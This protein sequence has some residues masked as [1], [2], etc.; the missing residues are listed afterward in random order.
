MPDFEGLVETWIALFG[1]NEETPHC[2]GLCRQYWDVDWRISKDRRALLDV[3]RSRF[4]VQF[5]PLVRILRSLTGSMRLENSDPDIGDLSNYGSSAQD[6][7]ESSKYVHFYFAKLPT[8]T[9]I[10]P[11]AMR[12][13]ANVLYDRVVDRTGYSRASGG[14]AYTNLRQ[15]NLPGGTTIPA[16]CVGRLLSSDSSHDNVVVAWQHEHSGWKLVV[17]VL[18]D[19]VYRRQGISRGIRHTDAAYGRRG[20]APVTLSV[21][22]IGIEDNENEALV[23]DGLELILSIVQSNAP[24]TVLLM[25]SLEE[26]GPLVSHSARDVAPPDLVQLIFMILEDVLG[27][28]HNNRAPVPSALIAPC[29]GILT[30]L[31]SLPNYSNRVWLFLRSSPILFGSDRDATYNSPI[32][33]SERNSG[34]YVM[35]LSLLRLVRTLLEESTSRLVPTHAE[36]P[37]LQMIKEEV[38][39]RAV[40]FIQTHIWVEHAG[41]RY[42]HLPDRFEISRSVVELYARILDLRA[43]LEVNGDHT[44]RSV[45]VGFVSG[46]FITH[47]AN[48]TIT[49]LVHAIASART[50]ISALNQARRIP[51]LHAYRELLEKALRLTRL[52]LQLKNTSQDAFKGQA[53]LEQALCADHAAANML[54]RASRSFAPD[55]SSRANPVDVLMH[56]I[57]Q[58]ELGTTIPIESTKV[59]TALCMAFADNTSPDARP[60]LLSYLSDAHATMAGLVRI[61]KHPYDDLDLRNALW[62]FVTT[63]VQIQAPL[64]VL[65]VAGQFR[66]QATNAKG[67]A[68]EGAAREDDLSAIGTSSSTKSASA[69]DAACTTLSGWKDLWESNPQLL[70][71]VLGFLEVVWS[72][73]LENLLSL[74]PSKGDDQFWKNIAAIVREELG[75]APDYISSK[76]QEE[77]GEMHSDLHSAVQYH[78]YKT[79]VKAHALSILGADIA[80]HLQSAKGDDAKTLPASYKEIASLFENEELFRDSISET[81][82]SSYDS[83]LFD[84]LTIGLSSMAPISLPSLMFREPLGHQQFGDGFMLSIPL[85]LA[86]LRSSL[87]GNTHM[88]ASAENIKLLVFSANQNMSLAHS[89]LSMMR[90]WGL[91]LG[92]V[93]GH[94][95]NSAKARSIL[96]SAAAL[97]SQD[98]A[99]ESRSGDF[100]A[101]IH[102]ARLQLLLALLEA[103]WYTNS[104]SP[105]QV[106][107]FM[108][109]LN[110]V[111][112]IIS[113]ETFPPGR[114]FLGL[115][116]DAFHRSL[117][118]IIYF[119]AKKCQYLDMGSQIIRA[120]YRLLMGKVFTSSLTLVIDALRLAFDTAR[121]RQ[122]VD[123]DKDLDLLVA[124]FQQCTRKGLHSSSTTWLTR[125]QEADVFSASLMLLCQT[126]MSGLSDLELLRSRGRPLYTPQVLAFHMALASIPFTAERL[127]SEGA[128]AAYSNN[129]ISV[130]LSEGIVAPTL[131]ELPSERSPAHKAY[132]AML[133]NVTGMIS[134]LASPQQFIESQV[135]GFVQ[136]YGLQI[137]KALSWTNDDPLTLPFLEE[138]ELSVKLFYLMAPGN[139]SG[140]S[141]NDTALAPVLRAFTEVALLLVQQLNYALTHPKHLTGILE[142][143]TVEERIRMEHESSENVS[144]A[145]L[146]D[147]LD[148][149]KRPIMAS[150][151]YR[152]FSLAANVLNTLSIIGGAET[153]LLSDTEEWPTKEAVVV[154]V[155]SGS[156]EMRKLC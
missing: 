95:R 26:G 17:D 22:D 86:V 52:I 28:A 87:A 61:L 120:E 48:P 84:R 114:S 153:V 141:R 108:N 83:E 25:Q 105:Q 7:L 139:V 107:D 27:R 74:E 58:R 23:A 15:L 89:Q 31:L 130:A 35:T 63:A 112:V 39:L 62:G 51:E 76:E 137:T 77:D 104:D 53:L 36:Q 97:A 140:S 129:S 117:L 156:K 115:V 32:L 142:P 4:P 42:A 125:C 34:T 57:G 40:H 122:D 9:Q 102:G 37:K 138:L 148:A 109:V 145:N 14:T 113:S 127:A 96:L 155:C 131:P 143:I 64:A 118:L 152:L 123:L 65:F 111:G 101:T 71:S 100:M 11:P 59:L 116:P 92:Q 146:T 50:V 121:T 79:T 134:N 68:K 72:R 18:L 67:K 47:A 49:P 33:T 93:R 73:S 8:Y 99:K 128:I 12:T 98:I 13:G 41:W 29:L 81:I 82:S 110:N 94:L 154:P 10:L 16:K 55:L 38:L 149:A 3:A 80:V 43:V 1:G 132:C 45:L 5:R 54:L 124:V 78:A 69:V 85:L 106:K 119:C 70:A 6:R 150:V 144:V 66:V 88:R 21:S 75:P 19:Y 135:I 136:L 20:D 91:L 90:A 60:S 151:I 147:L 24:L 30:T 126:D 2:A 56:L 103:A 46:V 133:A 44:P